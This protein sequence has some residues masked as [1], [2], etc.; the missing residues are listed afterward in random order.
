MAAYR[1][2]DQ[3]LSADAVFVYVAQRGQSFGYD[4]DLDISEA[5]RSSG[6]DF[7]YWNKL[8]WKK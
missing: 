2:I 4:K 7:N 3:I 1:E 5:E 6:N 8:Q